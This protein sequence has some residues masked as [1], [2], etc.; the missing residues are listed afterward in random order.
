[1]TVTPDDSKMIVFSSGMFSGSKGVIP[2][3][4]H[5]CPISTEGEMLLWKNPQKNDEKNRT[6]E[7]MNRT[8]PVF[9]PFVTSLK[10]SPCINDSRVT[11]RHQ[12]YDEIM[13]IYSDKT[14]V[15]LVSLLAHNSPDDTSD[16]A[17]SEAINGHGLF[18]TM[19]IL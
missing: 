6:S 8:I 19:C 16:N 2:F 10:C 12:Q 3:G 15:I 9:R 18:S 13:V 4:G 11:S 14:A 7:A 5:N 17:L 1:M